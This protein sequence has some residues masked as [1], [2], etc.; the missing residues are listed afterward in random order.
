MA[1]N[2]DYIL[3]IIF[4]LILV[5]I[6]Y[7]NRHRVKMEKFLFPLF[8]IV[9]Y[10]TKL[11]LI[12][13]DKYSKK[14]PRFLNFVGITSIIVGFIGMAFVFQQVLMSAYTILLSPT[15]AKEGAKLLL[16]GTQIGGLRLS[17]F[18][19]IITIFIL[20]VVH[21][22]SHGVIARLHNVKVK[23]SGFAVLGILLPIFPA[24]FVE[25]DEK[26]LSKRSRKAQLSVLAVGSFSNLLMAAVFF[27]LIQFVLSPISSTLADSNGIIINSLDEKYPSFKAGISLGEEIKEINGVKVDNVNK[28]IEEAKKIEKGDNIIL[29]TDI[30]S[31]N[32]IAAQHPTNKNSGYLGLSISPKKIEYKYWIFFIN[33]VVG[34]INLFPIMITDGAKMFYVGLSFFIKDEQRLK[35]V[36]GSVNLLC[37]FLLLI[38]FLPSVIK[39]FMQIRI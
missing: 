28:F 34:L 15:T 36:W 19:W 23:S 29:K 3:L 22:F 20:A 2:I 18:H 17:F 39:Y 16:P 14:Y 33:L 25:P 24:A 9:M 4:G 35:K 31:Y 11:G 10:R 27:I 6:M 12:S 7:I 1:L 30:N 8:Y 13:M 26:E 38:N 21:E 37:I 5:I 32:L